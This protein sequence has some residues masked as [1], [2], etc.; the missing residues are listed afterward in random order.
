MCCMIITIGKIPHF[1]LCL[2]WFGKQAICIKNNQLQHI[3]FLPC[4]QNEIYQPINH[5]KSF[6]I[7][8]FKQ[9]QTIKFTHQIPISIHYNLNLHRIQLSYE[10]IRILS[11]ENNPNIIKKINSRHCSLNWISGNHHTSFPFHTIQIPISMFT[12]YSQNPA[13]LWKKIRVSSLKTT[14]MSLKMNP[15]HHSWS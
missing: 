12:I 6:T 5:S 4:S 10:K 11:L 14:Q 8:S 7:Q 3:Q 1:A 15:R 9:M 13:I 2:C